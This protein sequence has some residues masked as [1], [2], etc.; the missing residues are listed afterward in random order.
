MSAAPRIL[1]A[2]TAVGGHPEALSAAEREM[3]F[4]S[5]VALMGADPF[6]YGADIWIDLNVSGPRQVARRLAFLRRAVRDYDVF[7]FNFGR[8]II[9]FSFG[10]KVVSELPLLRMLGKKIIVTFQGCDVRLPTHCYCRIEWCA[11]QAEWRLANAKRILRHADRVLYCNPDLRQWLPGAEFVPYALVD[12]DALQ[13]APPP[14]DRD[15]MRIYHAPTDRNIKG[16]RF[17]IEAVDQLRSEGLPVRLEILEGLKREQVVERC[18]DADVVVDQLLIGWYGTFAAEAMALAKPVVAYIR[19]EQPGDNPFGDELPIV[20]SD[21]AQ[22]ADRLR[23]LATNPARRAE[24]GQ[25]GR[26]FAERHHDPATVARSVLD[27]VV[28]LPAPA[29]E[30]VPA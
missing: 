16:T 6:G 2:P 11:H 23:E 10:K 15:E 20:R 17:V 30:A 22:L 13:P 7:H 1:H 8:S 21:P 29:R 18:R 14:P 26:R 3:G 5:E 19:D 12:L 25:A 9:D 4:H 27:G 28:D 24:I